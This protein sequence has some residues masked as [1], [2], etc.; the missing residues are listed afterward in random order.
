MHAHNR[1]C[2]AAAAIFAN[3]T[4]F[5][6]MPRTSLLQ[7]YLNHQHFTVNSILV[8]LHHVDV[9]DVAKLTTLHF[10]TLEMEV[11]VAPELAATLPIFTQC[12][13]ST[14]EL[15]STVNHHASLKSVIS[16]YLCEI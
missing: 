16:L 4:Y 6:N 10:S 2:S 8:L 13:H 3:V 14:T 12:N 15:T 7:R 1:D 5:V 11:H 9:G